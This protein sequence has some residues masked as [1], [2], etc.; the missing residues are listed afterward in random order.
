MMQASIML[1]STFCFVC[2]YVCDIAF[3]NK[4]K[5]QKIKSLKMVLYIMCFDSTLLILIPMIDASGH[6]ITTFK[7]LDT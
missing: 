5:L 3:E 6:E 7:L 4:I 2:K 1:S